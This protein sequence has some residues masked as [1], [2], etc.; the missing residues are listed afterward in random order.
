MKV[1]LDKFN[2]RP[3]DQHLLTIE[4]CLHLA[5]THPSRSK[6]LHA[7]TTIRLDDYTAHIIER[8]FTARTPET[9][10]SQASRMQDRL[11]AAID[12]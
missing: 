7:D 5:A 9:R 3:G 12:R 10:L 2:I 1:Y 11:P 6:S 4:G 8:E